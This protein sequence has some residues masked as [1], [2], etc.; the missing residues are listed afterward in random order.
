[1]GPYDRRRPLVIDPVVSYATYLGGGGSDQVFALAVDAAGS[2]YL[3]GNTSSLDFPVVPGA[4]QPAIGGGVDAFV[5]KLNPGGSA[6]IYATY[7]GGSGTDA[8]RGLAVDAAGQAY[9]TGFTD[10]A[11][12]PTTPGALQPLSGGDTDAFVVR[13]GP[14]GST[15]GYATYLGGSRSDVGL[16]LAIDVAGAAHVAG[17]TFSSD[18]PVVGGVQGVIGGG[19]CG[20]GP[21]RDAFVS[22]LAPDGASLAY[23]TYLGGAGTDVAT[24]IGLDPGG[25]AHVAG[26]TDSPDLPATAGAFR[27]TPAG[28][29]DAFVAALQPGG[30]ALRYAAYLGGGAA[31]DAN[32]LAVDGTGNAFVVGTTSSADFPTTV[33]GAA[34]GQGQGFVT[35]VA[36][37]G[38]GL[39]YSTALAALDAGLDVAVD[40]VGRAV[41]AGS[42]LVCKSFGPLGQCLASD[43]DAVVLRLEADGRLAAGAVQLLGGTG[44]DLGLTVATD[45]AGAAYVAGDTDSADFPVTA[46]AFQSASVGVEGFAARV[47]GF[48]GGGGTG[49]TGSG[50]SV[51]C[52]IATAAFGSP[53]AREVAVLRRFRD[54]V[55]LAS[56]PGRLLAA[57]YA[58]V[59]PP[60]ARLIAA[61][62]PL[63][64]PV[65]LALRP[66]IWWADLALRAPGLAAVVA[67]VVGLAGLAVV[68]VP[69]GRRRGR[70]RPGPAAI[71]AGSLLAATGLLGLLVAGRPVAPEPAAR[72]ETARVGA[73][74]E[75]VEEDGGR[76]GA[77][78]VDAAGGVE[79][80]PARPP[81]RDALRRLVS[82]TAATITPW[83]TARGLMGLRIT[84]P[85][86][87]VLATADGLLV[88]EPGALGRLGVEAGDLI[89]R[90]DGHGPAGAIQIA[91]RLLRDPDA[92]PI[93][94]EIERA[95]T[96]V[97]RP[98][99]VR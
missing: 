56:G 26:S 83:P 2:A 65:R 52:F 11:D 16:A 75:I 92:G 87:E 72:P 48:P 45:A 73:A 60:L 68:T 81:A 38:S 79:E 63:G 76:R 61:Q 31:D 34:S 89:R 3:A 47:V 40:G 23:S 77:P 82:G 74:P 43:I 8:A 98:M 27:T 29:R 99:R 95:G 32:S 70:R 53:L 33:G 97:V 96:T 64:A 6:L 71:A 49:S 13:L 88:T 9:V 7:L 58:A 19:V 94:V 54:A 21:C 78:A 1:M 85:L 46:G 93:G 57:G 15:L 36:P 28:G 24:G 50:V 41:V 55:L 30:G 5:A 86:G 20:A 59:S 22:K 37:D 51:S 67:A 66:A 69:L 80:P 35:R 14:F 25:A 4:L 90:I 44:T 18:F 17:G 10:S 62:P 84:S 39:G 42:D 12:F 91:A